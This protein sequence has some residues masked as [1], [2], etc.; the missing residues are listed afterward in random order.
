M[1][2]DP[3]FGAF[4]AVVAKLLHGNRPGLSS[5][6]STASPLL[7]NFQRIMVPFPLHTRRRF[8][9]THI[10][11]PSVISTEEVVFIKMRRTTETFTY[12]GRRRMS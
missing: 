9:T 4:S 12:D 2:K 1:T 5:H 10:Q 3:D 6:Q 11:T 7:K 8:S